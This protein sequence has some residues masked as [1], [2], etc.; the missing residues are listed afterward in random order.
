[1]GFTWQGD[2]PE[3]LLTE[4]FAITTGFHPGQREIIEQLVLGR[5][6]LAIQRT[7]WGK[8]L[9]YQMASLYFP[10]LTIVFSP[11]KALMRDQCQRCN[12][13]GLGAG[14]ISS[15]FSSEENRS[16][17]EKAQTNNFKILFIAPERLDN[18]EWQ[19]YL[20]KMRI[21]MV[22]VDEAHCISTWGHDFRPHYRRIARLLL[23]LPAVTS[24]L[25]LTA[26]ANERVERDILQQIGH[27]LVIRG[28]LQRSNLY[29]NVVR[30]NGDWEKLCYLGE[31]LLHHLDVGIVYTATQSSATMVATF[32]G[33]R[34]MKTEYYHAGRE[35][36]VRRRI[37][38]ELMADHYN[39]ICSTTALGMG[40]DKPDIRFVIHYHVP[41]SPIHYYQEMGRAGRDGNPSWCILL[42][43]PADVV[44]HEHLHLH[45]KPS[46]QHYYAVLSLLHS[47]AHGLSER[48]ILLAT[49]LS[50]LSVRNIIADLE[51]Q[52]LIEAHPRSR[53][54]I[55]CIPASSTDVQD[56]KLIPSLRIDFSSYATIQQQKH[57]ELLAM[58]EYAHG[59]RCYMGYLIACLGDQADYRCGTC[60]Y[61]RT[62]NFPPVKTSERIQLTVTKFLEEEFLPCIEMR[63]VDDVLAHEAGW[64]LAYHKGTSIGRLVSVSKYR[65][66]G[67][68]ALGLVMRAVEI[69]RTRYPIQSIEGVVSVPPTQRS[70]LVE[71]FARQVAERLGMPYLPVLVKARTTEKQKRLTNSLQKMTNVIDAFS[72]L[73]PDSIKG[74]V[75]LLID[76][77]FDSGYTLYEVGKVLVKTG[78]RAVYPFTITRTAHSDDQ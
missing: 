2:P 7:G 65:G 58:Q 3:Q 37:E 53:R 39:V 78:A 73:S 51:E 21:S 77:I 72:I 42:Y 26:T 13:V 52:S 16:T 50:K 6:V 67:P 43:D 45:A 18:V 20:L 10:Y 36:N 55:A 9:C 75:L 19:T 74:R 12:A 32:L 54:Y 30:L 28:S 48:D 17:L 11:L 57:T 34:G 71:M 27:P 46:E 35:G 56:H 62:Q 69:V 24:V 59:E 14:I 60:G 49:G 61:C 68:F 41:P 70:M 23:M 29:V 8:S 5:R 44:I 1:M 64:A 25:A 66:G 63:Y 4:H 47:H 40:I 31:V 33:L 22:V 76:D 15:D 38:Q